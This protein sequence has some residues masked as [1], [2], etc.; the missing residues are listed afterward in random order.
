MKIFLLILCSIIFLSDAV[1]VT[2]EDINC[3]PLV[4]YLLAKVQQ[5][6]AKMMAKPIARNTREIEKHSVD[7]NTGV[8]DKKNYC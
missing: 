2:S 5:L 7:T 8:D 1:E 6:E 3:S 4:S